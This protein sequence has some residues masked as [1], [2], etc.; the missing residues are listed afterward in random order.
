MGELSPARPEWEHYFNLENIPHTFAG[1]L[2][3]YK[4]ELQGAVKQ[5]PRL[6][7]KPDRGLYVLGGFFPARDNIDAFHELTCVLDPKHGPERSYYVD[8]NPQPASVLTTDEQKRFRQAKLE[9]IA[10]YFPNESVD[11]IVLDHIMQFL[12]EKALEEALK[13]IAAILSPDGVALMTMM[14]PIFTPLERIL[15]SREMKVPVY[16]R[17]QKLVERA[18]EGK[19][20]LVDGSV[21]PIFLSAA[22][23]TIYTFARNDSI[24][25]PFDGRYAMYDLDWLRHQA[26]RESNATPLQQSDPEGAG[27]ASS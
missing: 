21:Y 26:I 15:R 3:V 5:N 20:K 2:V 18:L 19:V 17:K 9:N 23:G 4:N 16:P 6:R 8:M 1:Q 27:P 12:D 24:Y 22:T 7:D 14:N 11:L 25:E 13:N 10:S